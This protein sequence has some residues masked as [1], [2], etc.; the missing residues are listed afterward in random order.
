[1]PPLSYLASL[2]A[3]SLITAVETPEI[4]K[5]NNRIRMRLILLRATA[6]T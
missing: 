2:L 1:M 5:K 4:T 6:I 3:A